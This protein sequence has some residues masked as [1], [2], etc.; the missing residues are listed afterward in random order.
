MKRVIIAGFLVCLMLIA[1]SSCQNE[2]EDTE[3]NIVYGQVIKTD[4][5][6]I[7]VESGSYKY[8]GEFT[9]TGEE[10]TYELPEHVFFDDFQKGDIVAVLLDGKDATAVTNVKDSEKNDAASASSKISSMQALAKADN[11]ELDINDESYESAADNKAVLMAVNENGRFDVDRT[12]LNTTGRNAPGIVSAAGGF[13]EGSQVTANTAGQE[14]PAVEAADGDS[15]V[16]LENSTLETEGLNSPC[17]E[18]A[19]NVSLSNVTVTSQNS[20]AVNLKGTGVVNFK[21]SNIVS[22]GD[23]A[24]DIAAAKHGKTQVSGSKLTADHSTIE[25]K[26]NGALIKITGAKT[27][28]K[29]ISTQLLSDSGV[30]IDIKADRSG[31]GARLLLYGVDQDF[32]GDINCDSKS[33]VKMVLTEGSTFTGALNKVN[34]AAYSKICLSE[35][36]VWNMTSDSYAG[37]INNYDETC[38]NINSNGYNIYYDRDSLANKWLEGRT[39]ELPGGGVLTPQK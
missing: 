15:T 30:F 24:F 28:V 39:I 33:K 11:E 5:N 9:G 38:A 4:E 29:M 17:V 35:D 21:D 13:A 19:G 8:E 31:N 26:G 3:N 34:T 12:V 32:E 2:P 7:T 1:L 6:T 10:V 36:S 14:S 16:E 37:S 27:A 25:S 22:F 18:S 23:T 20:G